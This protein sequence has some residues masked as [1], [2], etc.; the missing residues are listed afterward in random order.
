MSQQV[1]PQKAQQFLALLKKDLNKSDQ[2]LQF[3]EA[4]KSAIEKRDFDSYN[5]LS[6]NKKQLLIEIESMERERHAVMADMGFSVDKAGFES[7]LTQVPSNWRARFEALWNSLTDK[8]QRCR[9][10]NQVN[11]KILLHAQIATERL[12]QML[13]GVNSN[14]TV[15]HANG[16]T[17]QTGKNRCL[18]MA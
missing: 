12:M 1:T 17:S 14:Q 11:G 10:L 4:E 3:L 15:Y 13:Q 18:A 9:A 6:N 2:L 5:A 8:L 7:F 16:R